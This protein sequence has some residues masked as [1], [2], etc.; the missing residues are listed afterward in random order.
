MSKLIILHEEGEDGNAMPDLQGPVQVITE[1][2]NTITIKP[3]F[4]ISNKSGIRDPPKNLLSHL[5]FVL[6]FTFAYKKGRIGF[7]GFFPYETLGRFLK[8]IP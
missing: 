2:E 6:V 7:L 5:Q 3:Y 4:S 1:R 8:C